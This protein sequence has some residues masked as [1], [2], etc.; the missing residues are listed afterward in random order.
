MCNFLVAH[1]LE[2]ILE[3]RHE[4][5]AVIEHGAGSGQEDLDG[6]HVHDPAGGGV[7]E[8]CRCLVDTAMQSCLFMARQ[9]HAARAMDYT[10]RCPRGSGGVD[11]QERIREGDLFK[12]RL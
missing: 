6:G 10:F 5:T 8:L 11:D 2:E 3:F 12:D 4:G 1:Q 9:Y 7:L